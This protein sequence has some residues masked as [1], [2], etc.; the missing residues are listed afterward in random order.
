M[1]EV[2]HQCLGAALAQAMHFLPHR[3]LVER[4]QDPAGGIDALGHLGP[5][6]ARDQ[7]LEAP[8]HAV[9]VGASAATEL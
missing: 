5:Q 1:Y 7:R 8:G 6:I 3:R 9:R 2:D 4:R